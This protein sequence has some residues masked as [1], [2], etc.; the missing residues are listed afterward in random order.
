[1]GTVSVTASGR[2][3]QA[4]TS[5]TPHVITVDYLD[6][7]LYPDGS[8]AA[9]LNY[10]RNPDVWDDTGVWCY[11]MDP[12]K[13]WEFCDVPLC[14]GKSSFYWTKDTDEQNQHQGRMHW[15]TW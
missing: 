9:A 6:D 1:M 8:R 7:S 2:Q 5:N 15:H 10:C 3:C 14:S 12:A 4:W 11:T 13:R